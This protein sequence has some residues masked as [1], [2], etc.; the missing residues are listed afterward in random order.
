MFFYVNECKVFIVIEKELWVLSYFVIIWVVEWVFVCN[1]Y[2][3]IIVCIEIEKISFLFYGCFF[4]VVNFD[5]IWDYCE[6]VVCYL[7]IDG[8]WFKFEIWDVNVK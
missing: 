6:V 3:F 2:V 7:L 1:E 5:V 4:W 8:I